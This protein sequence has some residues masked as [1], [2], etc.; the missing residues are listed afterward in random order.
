MAMDDLSNLSGLGKLSIE[1]LETVGID[2]LDSLSRGN[3]DELLIEMTKANRILHIR[4]K[5]PTTAELL[6]WIDQAREITGYDPESEVTKLEEIVP[7]IEEALV[8][9]PVQGSSLV[10]KGV[11]ASD[12]PIIEVIQRPP[13]GVS[14]EKNILPK[15]ETDKSAHKE[16]VVKNVFVPAAKAPVEP[17]EGS[18]VTPLK[19]KERDYRTQASEGLN[20]GKKEHS[21]R[22]IR[23]V[24]YPQPFKLR[25]AAFVAVLFFLSMPIAIV[26]I[27]MIVQTGIIMWAAAPAATILLSLIYLVVAVRMK[28][29]ICGQPLYTP[30]GCLRH[31]K[32]H[33]FPL[34]GYILPTSIH[35]LF[36]NWFR[37]TY[38]G[39]SIRLKK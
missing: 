29:R 19:A 34:L 20:K 2:S 5:A 26:G 28:C 33:H 18:E 11:K 7:A 10:E 21:K 39:T 15:T 16:H 17:L 35:I 14:S 22:Y 12:V 38:C 13:K 30:K 25:L 37:C 31:I 24:L 8:A 9:I 23:G 1:L 36:F 3:A 27:V 32:A 6:K 4:K